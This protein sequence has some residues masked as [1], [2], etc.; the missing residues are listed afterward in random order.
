M[1]ADLRTRALSGIIA[2]ALVATIGHA[3][4][5]PTFAQEHQ[6]ADKPDAPEPFTLTITG[7]IDDDSSEVVGRLTTLFYQCYPELVERFEDPEKP[8]AREVRIVMETAMR[9]P[10][11][12]NRDEI[13]VSVD[14]LR[15]HPEDI[16]LLTHE[17]THVVQSYGR[18]G[19]SWLTEGIADYARLRYGPEDQPGWSLPE[20]LSE[21][22][23]YKDSYRVAARFLVWL[24]D[25]H[26][27]AV[28]Q[29]HRKLQHRE[30]DS[31]TFEALTG[32]SLDTLWDQCVSDLKKTS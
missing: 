3:T 1:T 19:P 25:R 30:Y 8:A 11:Y 10:A 27:D 5:S 18:A 26:P 21:S 24:D 7:E 20:Q 12:C 6:D 31:K 17:L 13:H 22:Q 28:D 4:P 32:D 16:G 14:W 9:V 15:K 29:L 2:I 23:S